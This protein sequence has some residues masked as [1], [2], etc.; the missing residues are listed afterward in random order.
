MSE[1][2]A[3]Q[4]SGHPVAWGWRYPPKPGTCCRHGYGGPADA[5]Y[6]HGRPGVLTAARASGRACRRH[7]PRARLEEIG[8]PGPGYQTTVRAARVNAGTA[9]EL[10]DLSHYTK[11][12][13]GTIEHPE[14]RSG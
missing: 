11:G 8:D 1:P 4:A 10:G 5:I 6:P 7:A 14:A 9:G 2:P 13:I 3:R 12:L